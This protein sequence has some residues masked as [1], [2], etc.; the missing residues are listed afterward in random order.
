M[1]KI[2]NYLN[3]LIVGNVYDA[4]DILDAYSTDHSVLKIKPKVVAIP[5]S[6]DDICKLMQFC[7]QLAKKDIKIPVTV[8]GSGLDEGGADLG[9]GL[10][11]STEKLSKLLESD[12]RERLVRVQSGITLKELNTALSIDGLTVPISGH[13]LDTIG[14]LISNAPLDPKAGKYGGIMN[15]IERVEFVLPN[16]DIVQTNRIGE[17]GLQKIAGEKTLESDIFEKLKQIIKTNEVLIKEIQKTGH[18]S[19]GYPGVALVQKNTSIDLMPLLFKAQGT[20]G[21]IT[22]VILRAVPLETKVS[23][24]VAT[25]EKFEMAQKYLELVNKLSPSEVNIYNLKIAKTVEESGKRLSK[26]ISK[27]KEGFVVFAKFD[28]NGKKCLR[29]IANIESTL[30][31]SSQLTLESEKTAVS[32][33]EFENSLVSFLN[34]I[35][36]GERVPLVTDFYIPPENLGSFLNDLSVME[37]SLQLDIALFGSY[38]TSNYSIR[39]KFNLEDPD[40]PKKAVAFLRASNYIIQRQGGSLTGGTPEGRVKAL[41]TNDN[42]PEFEKNLYIDIKNMFDKYGIMNPAVKLG[43]DTRYTLDHFRTTN[44]VKTVL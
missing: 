41:V 42:M 39:P 7:Y 15:Y 9:N 43:A 22:E 36:M 3:Q 32:L 30:P 4:P 18:S 37:E 6:T 13:E 25:F 35:R 24:A 31:R 29:R 11:V 28:Q 2:A 14:G 10:I 26:I 1:G 23:R 27:A 33:N 38:S 12:K 34:Q 19:Y 17:H 8:R 21:I 16:G 44:S 20:L 40:F 5:E